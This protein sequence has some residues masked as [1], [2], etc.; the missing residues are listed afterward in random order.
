METFK[1]GDHIV[2]PVNEDGKT[3]YYRLVTIQHGLNFNP[4]CGVKRGDV[5]LQ[6]LETQG[7]ASLQFKANDINHITVEEM[8]QTHGLI[9][10]QFKRFEPIVA[11]RMKPL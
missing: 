10:K 6:E 3:H 5:V 11:Y 1:A 4:R 8:N 7:P 2:I 9:G